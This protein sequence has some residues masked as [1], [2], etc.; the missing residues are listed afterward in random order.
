MRQR[1]EKAERQ[2]EKAERGQRREA[3]RQEGD[4]RDDFVPIV[5]IQ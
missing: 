4:G 5:K 3:L 2:E 1:E